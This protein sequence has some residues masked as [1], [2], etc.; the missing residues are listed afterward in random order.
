MAFNVAT[1]GGGPAGSGEVKLYRLDDVDY[2]TVKTPSDGQALVWSASLGKWQAN[3]VS[4]GGGGISNTFTTTVATQS[5]IPTSDVT[6]SI[7]SN[8][9]RYKDIWLSNSTIYLGAARLSVSG[10]K[11]IVNDKPL[12][13]NA[14]LTSTFIANTTARSLINQKMSVANVRSYM[15]V[16]NTKAYLANTNAFIKSQLANTNSSIASRA[17][18]TALKSTNTAIRSYVDTS[19]SAVVNAAPGTLNTLRELASAL[20]NDANFATSTTNLIATKISVANTKAY[21]AN[22]NAYIATR[23]TWASVTG[24]NTAIRSLV[25]D[26]L[27]VA[28]AKSYMQV[29]NTKAYLANTNAYIATK[30]STTSFNT[31]WA[32]T[33]SRVTL[34]NSNLTGTNTALRTLISDRLQVANAA[35]AYQTKSVE[36]A[37][38]ANTN[39]FIKSQLANTNAYIATRATWSS[40]TGTNTALRTL[41]NDRLQVANASATY[42]TKAVERAALANTNAF[43]KSQLANTNAYI[44]TKAS[45]TGLTSTNTALRTLISD[46]LQVANAATIYQ[47]KA[48]ERAA[49]AN[50]NSRINLLN[51]NLLNTNTTIRSLISSSGGSLV[52]TTT[53]TVKNLTQNDTVITGVTAAV[54]TGYL[55]VSNAVSTYATKASPTTSGLLAHTGRATISTNLAVSGNTSFGGL[56]NINYTGSANASIVIQ[57]TNTKGGTGY[58]DF[59]MTRNGGG[60]TNPNKWFRITSTGALEIIN[61]AYSATSLSL[62]DAGGLS[63]PGP[64]SVAGKQAV[65]GPAFRAYPA[66]AQTITSGSLQKVTFGSESYDTNNNFASSRF[67]PTIEGY[68]QLNSTVRLDGSNGTGECMIVIY[69]N[70]SEYARGWNSGGTQ[71]AANFWSMSVSDVIYANGTTDYFEIYIQQ[72]SGADRTTTAY[73]NISYFSGCMVRGA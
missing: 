10:T 45:W 19:V 40:V 57:G 73:Q 23:A 28:N 9:A 46:R 63:V 67:T 51:T 4:G 5:L 66:V 22:T 8:T 52:T 17:T 64:I 41:I 24:T 39:A 3:N 11:L 43:I 62:T 6:Y 68:Y 65:N 71:F 36:R 50:T 48:V 12:V 35:A 26:R 13:S 15:Q 42:Q 70:G 55:Q 1:A 59:L 37:A 27:Q 58:H 53:A 32:D 60:G 31:I 54:A 30:V 72:G 34:V 38:L 7:G 49:L 14:Y 33:N 16:S 69:K 20:A 61:S 47:T 25:S 29:A 44:A 18:W 56:V 2:N 21:L